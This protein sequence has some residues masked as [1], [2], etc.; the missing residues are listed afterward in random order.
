MSLPDGYHEWKQR[1][2]LNTEQIAN[3]IGVPHVVMV[4]IENGNIAP[5]HQHRM[6]I[7]SLMGINLFEQLFG[8]ARCK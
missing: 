2:G 7:E 5:H 1:S 8:N 4:H 6:K 3:R